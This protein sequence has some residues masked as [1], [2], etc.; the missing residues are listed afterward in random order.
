MWLTNKKQQKTLFKYLGG[1]RLAMAPLR[2][3]AGWARVPRGSDECMH[4]APPPH[5]PCRRFTETQ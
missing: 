3:G 5:M 2:V 4:C 1:R